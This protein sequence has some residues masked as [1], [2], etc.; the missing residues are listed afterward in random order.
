MCG[1]KAG[2]LGEEKEGGRNGPQEQINSGRGNRNEIRA[3]KAGEEHQGEAKR[4]RTM[5]SRRAGKGDESAVQKLTNENNGR[6]R[7]L[8]IN[9]EEDKRRT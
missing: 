2:R 9:R 8:A 7:L 4:K 6:Q 5:G 1:S 3:K